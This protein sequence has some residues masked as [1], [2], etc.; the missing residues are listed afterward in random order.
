MKD[1]LSSLPH[2]WPF[3]LLDR[4][5]EVDERRGVFIKLVSGGDPCVTPSGT[6]PAAFLVEAL[7]QA[8]GAHMNANF[9]ATAGF[10]AK[11]DGFVV[12]TPVQVGDELRI[13]VELQRRLR[14]ASLFRGRI[15]VGDEVRAEGK[16]TLA[17]PS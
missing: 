17:L 12:R 9:G 3:L 13:E 2:R 1:L 5:L 11:V 15:V 16:F 10:L 6:V 7:A 14:G 8:G 4:V